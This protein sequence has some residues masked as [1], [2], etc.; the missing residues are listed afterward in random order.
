VQFLD[1]AD[2]DPLRTE[3]HFP[4][5]VEDKP[6]IDPDSEKVIFHCRGTA[7][8]EM[9]GRSNAIAIRVEFHPKEMRVQNLPDLIW[10]FC[11]LSQRTVFPGARITQ[12]LQSAFPPRA[13][14]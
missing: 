2:A 9:P 12:V 1:G 14:F 8:K 3:F 7:K 4:R 10:Y 11:N 13:N 5:Q 6:A